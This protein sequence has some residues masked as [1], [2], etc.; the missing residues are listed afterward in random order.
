MCGIWAALKAAGFTTEQA[1]AYVKKLEPRGPEYTA[2]NDISG[3]LLG[4]TRLAINGLTPLGHQPFLQTNTATV[5]NGEIYNYKELAARWNLDLPEGTS[6]CAIIPHLA[7]RLPPTEL[8]RTLDGVFAFAHVNTTTNTLLVTRDPYG[9]RPLFEA[10]YADGST[11]W[12][13]EIKGLPTDYTQIEPFPPGTWRLYNILTGTKISEHKYHEVPHVKIAAL[14]FPSGL[15]LAKVTLHDAL[16]S[17]VKKRLLSDRPIGALLSGGLDSS[18]VAAIAARELKLNNK[19]LHTFSIGMPGSTDLMYARM[20][21]E[22]IKSEHHEVVV[23]PEDFLNAI[24]QVVHDI[25]SYDITTVRASVGNWLIGKYIKENTDIKVVFNGDGSDE[26]GGGYL[27]FY[28]APS[29]EEFEAESERLLNEIHL[30]DVLRSDR[31]MAAHGL[32][33]RTPFLDKNVV[34]TWRAIA[35]YLRRPKVLSPEGRGA[36]MEKFILREAFV[37]DHYLPLDVLMRKKE[38]FSDGVS[39]TTDSWYLRTSEYAKTIN[40]TDQQTEYSHNPPKTDEARWYRQLFVQ[41]Y[42]DKAATLIP[43]MW[44]PRWI[45]GATDPSARTLKDLYP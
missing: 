19:K 24:P 7:T 17:A 21:A 14:G 34:A 43:R 11:I 44:L 28:K 35:T 29:D 6:D 41:N 22:F 8:V 36:M 23:T 12:S 1:L 5:C 20:V 38:A 16:T 30:Y 3:V 18:L 32:E 42:G 15:S 13:S 45:E 27:Y 26:I 40:Q 9:V 2:L 39:A 33:A 4:F 10:Q 37:Y 31:S 25:E